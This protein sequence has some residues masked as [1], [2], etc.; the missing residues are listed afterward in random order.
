[1]SPC[2]AVP[3]LSP[4]PTAQQL[5]NSPRVGSRMANPRAGCQHPLQCPSSPCPPSTLGVTRQ[6]PAGD[7]T[8][9]CHPHPAAPRPNKSSFRSVPAAT[10]GFCSSRRSWMSCLQDLNPRISAGPCHQSPE[11]NLCCMTFLQEELTL[12][13]L[14]V[15]FT[16]PLQLGLDSF[17]FFGYFTISSSLT[18]GVAA[19]ALLQ[20][21]AECLQLT[22][23][24]QLAKRLGE[25]Q[26]HLLHLLL[27]CAGVNRRLH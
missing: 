17:P 12:F 1:M 5:Q 13:C 16:S 10:E 24:S 14:W 21:R 19:A 15:F 26:W 27:L 9:R 23:C 18:L 20:C 4:N 25:S 11:V 22:T 6:L 2:S 3:A 7:S 8:L